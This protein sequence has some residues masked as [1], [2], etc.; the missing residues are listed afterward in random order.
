MQAHKYGVM[1]ERTERLHNE[2]LQKAS[3]EV[4]RALLGELNAYEEG[5]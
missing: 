3:E 5:S 4:R 2:A 1:A